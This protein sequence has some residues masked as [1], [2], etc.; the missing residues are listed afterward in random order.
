[1]RVDAKLDHLQQLIEQ[2][3]SLNGLPAE[4]G[5][6]FIR[7]DSRIQE[8]VQRFRNRSTEVQKPVNHDRNEFSIKMKDAVE[9]TAV[10]LPA[11]QSL[12]RFREV[13]RLDMEYPASH[14]G[15]GESHLGQSVDIY[16]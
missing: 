16:A 14:R 1:M 2:K 15:G 6:P 7:K 8:S 13:G 9:Q 5:K 12:A 11:E 10:S 3:R 4:S